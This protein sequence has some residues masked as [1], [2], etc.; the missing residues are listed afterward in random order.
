M[1]TTKTR[2]TED[3]IAITAV[4]GE[5][6]NNCNRQWWKDS[7]LRELNVRLLPIFL[8][9]VMIGY[10]GALIGGLLTIPQYL[11]FSSKD[12]SLTGIMVAGYSIGGALMFWIVSLLGDVI[13]RRK[14]IMIGDVVMIATG[15]MGVGG[16]IIVCLGPVLLTEL[17][18]PRQRGSL[19]ATYS[20]FFYASRTKSTLAS[21][22][23]TYGS[24]HLRSEWS[25]RLPVVVQ[26]IPPLLQ[27]PLMMLVPESPRWLVAKGDV[28]KARRIL[29]TYHANGFESDQLVQAE[30]D[31]I[32]C[33]LENEKHQQKASWMAFFQTAGNRKRLFIVVVTSLMSQ[34]SGGGIITYYFAAALKSV[35]IRQPLQQAGINGGL[36]TFNFV[37]ALFS[38]IIVDKVG[39]RVLFLF[40]TATM[41]LAMVGLTVATQQFSVTARSEAGSA[42]VVMFFVFQLGFDSGYAPLGTTYLAEICPFYLRAKAVALHYFITMAS[43]AAG[44]YANP[45]AMADLGWKY[46]LVYVSILLV[47]FVVAWISFPETKG[48]TVEEI[49]KIFDTN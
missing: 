36:Q 46:Y 31:Q 49:T 43:A 11:G 14:V 29:A 10:D 1:K 30:Y 6:E 39:R 5:Q 3:N 2:L 12:T 18:H 41:L 48:Y 38:A 15:K 37:I 40:S 23:F 35:G 22:W 47:G 26:I 7:G 21:A 24:L 4:A 13:G 17:A 33:S 9:P 45:V 34:W 16:I 44:Q 20:S 25:W 27:L 19:V 8:S 32:C 28:T 42:V